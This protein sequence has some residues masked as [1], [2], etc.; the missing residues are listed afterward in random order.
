MEVEEAHHV[1]PD[2]SYYR[3]H[4]VEVHSAGGSCKVWKPYLEEEHQE[5]ARRTGPDP[6]AVVEARS[7]NFGGS[8]G[9][10][11]PDTP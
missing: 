5:E 3:K 4:S 6:K 1:A 11:D 8:Y 10:A 7:N 9:I 2:E